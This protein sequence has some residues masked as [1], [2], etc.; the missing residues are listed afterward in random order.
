MVILSV[1]FFVITFFTFRKSYKLVKNG[2]KVEGEIVDVVMSISN[3]TDED[4]YVTKTKMYAPVISFKDESGN[5][6]SFTSGNKSSRKRKFKVGVKKE[7]IYDRDDPNK[8]ELN[9]FGSL[10]SG[11]LIAGVVAVLF[12]IIAFVGDF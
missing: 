5:E 6:Y 4:G 10:W 11:A 3:S 9:S 2:N 8:A 12:L 7:V 1:I